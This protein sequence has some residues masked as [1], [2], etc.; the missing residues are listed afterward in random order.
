M[1]E[2]N[3]SRLVVYRWIRWLLARADD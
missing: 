3:E 1:C 2:T